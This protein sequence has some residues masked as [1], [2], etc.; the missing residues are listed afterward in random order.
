VQYAAEEFLSA[1]LWL[2]SKSVPIADYKGENSL[3]L[4]GRMI[5]YTQVLKSRIA[6]LEKL[7]EPIQDARNSIEPG[8]KHD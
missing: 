1:H 2:D 8:D 7:C 6:E 4:V 3:T 5:R